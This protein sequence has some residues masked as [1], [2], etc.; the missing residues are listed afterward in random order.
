MN[1]VSTTADHSASKPAKGTTQ[2]LEAA[3]LPSALLTIT[4]AGAIGGMSSATIYRK[5][6][7]D[8]SFPTLVRIG[9]RCT[10]IRAGEWLAWLDSQGAK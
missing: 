10:R 9:K 2:P 1:A 6:A 7:S 3:A 4:T 8:P 5:A